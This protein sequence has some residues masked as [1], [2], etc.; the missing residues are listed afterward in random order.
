MD[1]SY[2][3]V[4]VV[5]DDVSAGPEVTFPNRFIW[6]EPKGVSMFILDGANELSSAEEDASGS[7][8]FRTLDCTPGGEIEFEIAA[9]LGSEYHQG[10]P[11]DVAGR[12]RGVVSAPPE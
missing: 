7:I 1:K 3:R 2:W 10:P 6:E 8:V 9:T 12:F 4:W 5:L 11:V